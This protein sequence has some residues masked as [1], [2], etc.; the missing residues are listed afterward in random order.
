M[1]AILD[2][3]DVDRPPISTRIY[4]F[5][6]FTRFIFSIYDCGCKLLTTNLLRFVVVQR[7]CLLNCI[8]YLFNFWV[9]C[10]TW[11]G[12]L[13][14]AAQGKFLSSPLEGPLKGSYNNLITCVIFFSDMCCP[15][16]GEEVGE[17]Q[18]MYRKQY[19][20]LGASLVFWVK[21]LYVE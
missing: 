16:L 9:D 15:I 20:V 14:A 19:Y 5:F 12:A 10:Q 17:I 11:I 13:V 1:R 7:I 3:M 2:C 4:I 8:K 21:V 18:G 6:N